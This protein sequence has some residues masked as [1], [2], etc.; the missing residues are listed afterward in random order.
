VPVHQIT[1]V[2]T[3]LATGTAHTSELGVHIES[4][5]SDYYSKELVEL[6]VTLFHPLGS[7][8][9][10]QTTTIKR[11]SSIFFSGALTMIEDQLYI[12]LQN[13]CFVRNQ[14]HSSMTSKSMPWLS[15]STDDSTSTSF[16]IAQSIHNKKSNKSNDLQ[17]SDEPVVAQDS[18][19]SQGS[20]NIPGWARKT[21]IPTTNINKTI[22]NKSKNDLLNKTINNKSN[23]LQK[24]DEPVVVQ[25]LDNVQGSDNTLTPKA[26]RR[27]R[28]TLPT[29]TSTTKRKTR[30]SYKTSNKAQKLAD[31][32]TNIISVG[33]SDY[34]ELEDE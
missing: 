22:N 31:I 29:P 21:P 30:S 8:F 6:P 7:R 18:D 1:V 23:D 33:D 2:G 25:D 26:S 24:S 28:Q 32:A 10:N 14:I 12:E 15:K 19:N 5:I 3:A 34:E 9:K 4:E 20:N 17:K 16:N 11:G 13:F 27:T